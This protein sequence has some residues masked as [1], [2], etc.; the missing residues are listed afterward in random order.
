MGTLRTV[1][2][3][4]LDHLSGIRLFSSL[5]RKELGKVAKAV[6]EL[7]LPEGKELVTQGAP[8]REC[9]V[10]VE[11]QASVRIDGAEVAS[12]GPGDQFG[13]LALLDGGPRTATVVATSPMQVLVIGQREFA[14]VIDDVPELARK[15]LESLAA[16]IR[17]LDEQAHR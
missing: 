11:G 16:R 14:S 2:D 17:E 1:S 12:L 4:Y 8:G 10:I 5:S 7:S 9:F 6:D 15:L 13:E 3:K